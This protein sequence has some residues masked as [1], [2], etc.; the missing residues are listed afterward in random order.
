MAVSVMNSSWIE[1]D[2]FFCQTEINFAKPG[3]LPTFKT[4][5]LVT[6]VYS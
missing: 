3:P 5:L 6:T 2:G 4:K 1:L